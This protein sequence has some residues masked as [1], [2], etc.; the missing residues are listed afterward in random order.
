MKSASIKGSALFVAI[1]GFRVVPIEN[2]ANLFARVSA[3]VNSEQFQLFDAEKIA[4]WNHLYM[5]AVNAVKRIDNGTAISNNLPVETLL[6]ASCQDQ[7]TKSFEVLGVNNSTRSL[8][9]IVFA[10]SLLDAEKAFMRVEEKLGHVDDAVLQMSSSKYEILKKLFGIKELEIK[11]LE[12]EASEA[13]TNIL[14]ERGALLS[15]NR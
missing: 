4:G 6:T 7:I 10:D 9:L 1:G 14:V 3:A 8:A 5:A 15:L 11:A 2:F 12:K 13:L